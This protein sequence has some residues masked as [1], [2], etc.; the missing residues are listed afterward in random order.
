[1]CAHTK[2]THITNNGC[3]MCNPNDAHTVFHTAYSTIMV[4]T[5]GHSEMYIGGQLVP[6]AMD[7]TA[8]ADHEE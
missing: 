5:T 3:L 7:K 8:R 2:H 4:R 6:A 1:M